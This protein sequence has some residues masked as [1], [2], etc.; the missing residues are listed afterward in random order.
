MFY[1][2]FCN[3]QV[4]LQFALVAEEGLPHQKTFYVQLTL[5]DE[6]YHGSASSMKKAQHNVANMA[7]ERTHYPLPPPKVGKVLKCGE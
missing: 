3:F 7:L 5:G 6:V 4:S 2:L 1:G